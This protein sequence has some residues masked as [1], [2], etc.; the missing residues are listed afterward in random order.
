MIKTKSTLVLSGLIGLAAALLVGTGEYL[1]QFSPTGGYGDPNY[2]WMASIPFARLQMGHFLAILAAPLYLIGY[3]HIG[4]MLKP[5]GPRL[6][7]LVTLLGGY[8]FM[9]GAVWIG[10]RAF[11][12][13]TAAAIA[14][15]TAQPELLHTM[16]SLNEPLVNVLRLVMV[17]VSLIWVV[18]IMRGKTR[19]PRLMALFSP[20]LLLISIFAFF[21]WQPA[22][23]TYTVPTA[24]NTA[25]AV[26]FALSTLVALITKIDD[27]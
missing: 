20:L 14:Q 11:L 24:M 27:A 18:Q 19:Y 17:V 13:I 22:L 10:Q 26:L 1:L 15:G 12:G 5:A 9:V 21:A 8:G 4:Q 16:A 6:A 23:G 3:W 7:R 25:H 2:G